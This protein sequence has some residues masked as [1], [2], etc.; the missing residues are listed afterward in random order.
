MLNSVRG[1]Y[2]VERRKSK[3]HK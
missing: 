3:E 2:Q 1:N